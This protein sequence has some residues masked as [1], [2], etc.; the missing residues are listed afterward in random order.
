[1]QEDPKVPSVLLVG[2]DMSESMTVKDEVNSQT[3][4]DAVRKVLERCQPRS[5]NWPPSRT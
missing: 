4:I 2:I 1:M 5:T 3:R